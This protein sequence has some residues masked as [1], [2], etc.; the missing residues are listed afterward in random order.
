MSA[1]DP[2]RQQSQ[3][4]RALRMKYV[5]LEV[6]DL[7]L[8]PGKPGIGHRIVGVQRGQNRRYPHDKRGFVFVVRIVGSEN[9]YPMMHLPELVHK[10]ADADRDAI[11]YRLIAL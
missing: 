7:S 4:P 1:R 8:Q 2:D 11:D 6:S 3:K 9:T 5:Q 10:R